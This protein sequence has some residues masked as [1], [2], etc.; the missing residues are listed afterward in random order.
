MYL[1][2]WLVESMWP[3]EFY[4]KPACERIE[5]SDVLRHFLIEKKVKVTLRSL[6]I[7]IYK[8]IIT[9]AC[10]KIFL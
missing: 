8:I 4:L 5:S 2:K 10:F 6:E 9:R 1:G 3:I 7:I